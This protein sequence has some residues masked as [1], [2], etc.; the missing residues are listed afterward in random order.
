[1]LHYGVHSAEQRMLSLL[2]GIYKPF[3]R[4]NLLLD[5]QYGFFLPLIFFSSPVIFFQHIP[6]AFA[7]TELRGI[8]A[9]QRQ[10]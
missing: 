1:M 8:T 7:D 6:V 10:F 5:E 3:S 4:I 9:V 2:D